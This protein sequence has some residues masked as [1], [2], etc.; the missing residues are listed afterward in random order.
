[1]VVACRIVPGPDGTPATVIR[2]FGTMTSDLL[3]L[4][5]W[6]AEG[7]CT[8]VAMAS[9]GVFWKPIDHL[10]E[11]QF[12]V[13]VVNAHHLQAVPGRTTAVKDAAW[14]AD[15]LRH[16]LLRASF[17]PDRPPRAVRAL[18]RYRTTLV[19]ERTAEVNRLQQ[20]LEGANIQVAAV[21]STVVGTSG[22]QMRAELIQGTTDGVVLAHLARG[23]LRETIPQLEQALPGRMG[24]HQRFL[25]AQQLAP[26]DCLDAARERANAQIAQRLRP[27][28]V[29]V[30]RVQVIPGVGLRPAEV[31]IAELGAEL[32]R[33]PAARHRASWAGLCPGQNESAGK[34]RS[35]RTRKGS[36][37]L[38]TALVEAAQAAARTKNTS[39][40]AQFRRIAARRGAKR[41]ALA[42]VH[43]I[44]G[45]VYV[46]LTCPG[47]GYHD[48]GAQY[49]DEYFDERDRQAIERRLVRRL[50]GL[51]YHV[52]L[53]PATPAA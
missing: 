42:V 3:T 24:A 49:F 11:D 26:I 46:L 8:Q 4:A 9:T 53:D 27:F 14:I 41:A 51:G 32:N 23:R 38:R 18:T 20:V 16:G 7:G 1:M 40:A 2:T 21:A 31:L 15:L 45:P 10:L 30:V 5:D 43:R 48:L 12:T 34:H 22:R 17:I 35:G 25:L 39:L 6:R 33:L 28:D 36:P 47:V 37:W 50:E 44:L 29:A 19:Q 52:S 13:L